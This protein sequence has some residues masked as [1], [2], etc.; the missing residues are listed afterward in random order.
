MLDFAAEPFNRRASPL[1]LLASRRSGKARDLVAP[2]PDADQLEALLRLG[3]RV[4]DHGKLAPWR[5]VVVPQAQRAAFAQ[6]LVDAYRAEKPEAGRLELQAMQD[7]AQQAPALLA[8]LSTPSKESHIPLWEQELSA[9]AL[10][11][12]LLLAGHALGFLGNWLTGWPAYSPRVLNLL[13]AEPPARIAGFLFFGSCDKALEERP[14]PDL[15]T[16]V[17]TWAAT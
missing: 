13:G 3:T 10:C 12:N 2:G 7:F 15:G 11:Q 14:R 9:G 1:D 6:G 16:V 4:P 17:S 5:I 8:V